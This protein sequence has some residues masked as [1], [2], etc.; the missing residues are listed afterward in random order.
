DPHQIG[1]LQIVVAQLVA[2]IPVFEK[3]CLVEGTGARG[4]VPRGADVPADITRE[5]PQMLAISRRADP[6]ALERG[7]GERRLGYRQNRLVRGTKIAQE[8][9]ARLWI[10]DF[11][12]L[13]HRPL[14]SELLHLDSSP[15]RC[16]RPVRYLRT[17]RRRRLGGDGFAGPD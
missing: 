7:E 14:I 16:G 2:G 9:R 13:S 1:V 12:R 6:R 10:V 11:R 5:E 15:R 4:D 3:D 17:R 8:T